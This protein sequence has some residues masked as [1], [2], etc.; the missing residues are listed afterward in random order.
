MQTW[1]S[2]CIVLY[3]LASRD[4]SVHFRWL[5]L[6]RCVFVEQLILLF[7]FRIKLYYFRRALRAKLAWCFSFA[8]FSFGLAFCLLCLRWKPAGKELSSWLP[9]LLLYTWCSFLP[10]LTHISLA[11]PF[12]DLGKQCRP[13]SEC[14]VWSRSTLF[15]SRNCYSK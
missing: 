8:C 10:R 13:R 9:L 12:R 5:S 3:L 11:P 1:P 14:G 15:A 2:S 6:V 7:R 4:V